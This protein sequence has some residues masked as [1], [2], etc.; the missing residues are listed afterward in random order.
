MIHLTKP[1]LLETSVLL[2]EYVFYADIPFRSRSLV[3]GLL[4]AEFIYNRSYR[5]PLAAFVNCI[6]VVFLFSNLV[7]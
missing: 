1:F 5:L 6:T 7:T 2:R 4:T 3:M